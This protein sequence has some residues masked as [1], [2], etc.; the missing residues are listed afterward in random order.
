MATPFFGQ[1]AAASTSNEMFQSAHHYD[2]VIAQLQGMQNMADAAK[3]GFK[4]VTEGNAFAAA[5]QEAFNSLM[6]SWQ[7]ISDMMR[8][9]VPAEHVDCTNGQCH[10]SIRWLDCRGASCILNDTPLVS[11]SQQSHILLNSGDEQI[12]GTYFRTPK[13]AMFQPGKIFNKIKKSS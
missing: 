9:H 8:M 1:C 11:G 13:T 12:S 3:E 10:N 2:D 4:V 6:R 5:S 7:P